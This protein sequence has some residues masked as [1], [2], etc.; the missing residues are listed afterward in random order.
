MVTRCDVKE[1]VPYDATAIEGAAEG[2]LPNDLRRLWTLA[3]EIRLWEDISYGQWGCVLWSPPE[4]VRRHTEAYKR[5]RVDDWRAGDLILGEFLGDL[6]PVV[7]RC[8]P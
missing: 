4:V 1:A 2:R 3:S 8:D 7:I 5:R 6:E